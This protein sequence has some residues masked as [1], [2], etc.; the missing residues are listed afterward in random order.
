M[1][2]TVLVGGGIWKRKWDGGDSECSKWW[3]CM[4]S[5]GKAMLS[6]AYAEQTKTTHIH[7]KNA[8]NIYGGRQGGEGGGMGVGVAVTRQKICCTNDKLSDTAFD[9]EPLETPGVAANPGK[10]FELSLVVFM[11]AII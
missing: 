7:S 1:K 6:A 10:W 4:H 5:I 2:E 11:P 8:I 3:V 9:A